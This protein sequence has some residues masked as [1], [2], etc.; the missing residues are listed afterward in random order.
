ML[1]AA[2]HKPAVLISVALAAVAAVVGG[3]I[4]F[5]SSKASEVD[6]TSAK[7]VPADASLYFGMNTDL[8]SSQWVAA[9]D[10]VKRLG[11]DDPE[12]ELKDAAEGEGGVT[13]EDDVAPFLGGD[14][15]FF[16]RG[17]GISGLVSGG[18]NF[19]GGAIFRCNNANKA[20]DAIRR[21]A[22]VQL[23]PRTYGGVTYFVDDQEEGFAAVL[24]SH[25]VVT[26]SESAMKAVIDVKNGAPSLAANADFVQLRNDLTNNFLGFE[27]VDLQQL[28][29]KTLLSDP[30]V[31][32][33]LEQV[34]TDGLA[35]H[36]VG[37]AITASDA[38]FAFQAASKSGKATNPGVAPRTSKLAS[39]VPANALFF[40]STAG[41]AQAWQ[42]ALTGDTRKQLDK[43]LASEGSPFTIDQFLKDAGQEL[44]LGSLDELMKL[45]TGETALAGWQDANGETQAV[46]LAEV[47]NEAEA[48]TVLAK[49]AAAGKATRIRTMAVNG[50]EMTVF[51]DSGGD[52]SAYAVAD[53]VAITGTTAAV[54]AVLEGKGDKLS[55]SQAYTHSVAGLGTSLGSFMFFNL[56][57]ALSGSLG[58]S[59]GVGSNPALAALEGAMLNFV[60]EN[61]LA[62]V[63]GVVS[64]KK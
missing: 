14:A 45:L 52:D 63:S 26:S 7:L 21:Q 47:A 60:N 56:Q 64:I 11:V 24:G 12:Q 32:K 54:Q 36:P 62:R 22:D 30:A 50:K 5:T 53:G 59:I 19:D 15:S 37:G 16:I 17:G 42:E 18:L 43:T 1:A 55:G 39:R 23:K 31:R 4:L 28:I 13:W 27:Y 46:V 2:A 20:L 58:S 61:G 25:L 44:G 41:I 29:D 9:F 48:K 8:S 3:A 57:E 51:R 34:G 35:L 33:V 6:L 49:L 40:A 10:L 38:G